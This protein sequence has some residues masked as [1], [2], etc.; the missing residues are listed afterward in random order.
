MQCEQGSWLGQ[1]ERDVRCMGLL[2][3]PGALRTSHPGYITRHRPSSPA[4]CLPFELP[5]SYQRANQPRSLQQPHPSIRCAAAVKRRRAPA[6]ATTLSCLQASAARGC[7]VGGARP[8]ATGGGRELAPPACLPPAPPC[9]RTCCFPSH[10]SLPRP[11]FA[12][13]CAVDVNRRRSSGQRAAVRLRLGW[14][15]ELELSASCGWRCWHQVR[16]TQVPPYWG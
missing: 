2:L 5:G 6:Q 3:G 13:Q 7:S 15:P 10:R 14:V 8:G 12:M 4:H 16:G 1:G 9:R 11:S